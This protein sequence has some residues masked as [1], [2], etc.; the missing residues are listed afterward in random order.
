MSAPLQAGFTPFPL[1]S[2][3]PTTRPHSTLRRLWIA[4]AEASEAVSAG[5][6]DGLGEYEMDALEEERADAEQA[7][8]DHLLTFHG[9]TSADLKRSIL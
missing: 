6:R 2:L 4:A 9:L 8:R 3:A 5:Y 1:V 7:L